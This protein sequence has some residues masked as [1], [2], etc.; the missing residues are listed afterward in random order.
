MIHSH[1]RKTAGGILILY[2]SVVVIRGAS[3]HGIQPWVWYMGDFVALGFRGRKGV[4][5][6]STRRP[7]QA[8]Q[9]S[10]FE[11]LKPFLWLYA[12]LLNDIPYGDMCLVRFGTQ[13]CPNRWSQGFS[14]FRKMDRVTGYV[15]VPF[16]DRPIQGWSNGV[17]FNEIPMTRLITWSVWAGVQN[18][19]GPERTF[20]NVRFGPIL[21]LHKYVSKLIYNMKWTTEWIWVPVKTSDQGMYPV[22]AIVLFMLLVCFCCLFS[23]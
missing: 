15:R 17:I 11:D 4:P 3:Q 5:V 18:K 14:R 23:F 2:S 19:K 6:T 20:W 21:F 13:F 7:W 10:H 9:R 8:W 22:R 1:I 12:N 16:W